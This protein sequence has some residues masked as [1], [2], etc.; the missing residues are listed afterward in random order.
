MSRQP[1]RSFQIWGLAQISTTTCALWSKFRCVKVPLPFYYQRRVADVAALSQPLDDQQRAAIERV[2]CDKCAELDFRA[3]FTYRGEIF[4]FCIVNPFDL[5]QGD[6]LKGKFF[7]QRELAFLE[8]WVGPGA[9]I[10]EVG[11]YVGNH[12]VYYSRFMQP[13]S[14]IVLEPNPEAIA[15]LRRNLEANAVVAA[16]LSLLGIG[17]AAAAASYEL[18]CEGGANRGA[19]RLV[20]AVAGPVR[21]APL[22]DLVDSKV[23]FIKIDVEGMELEVLEGA[24]RVIAASRPKIMI[25]VFRPRIP[26][27]NEMAARASIWH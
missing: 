4:R 17:I 27:F 3:E 20:Q 10:V 14:V 25:E 23:D 1:Y 2:I 21:G 7:E 12:V 15:L 6:F 19:T 9:A 8:D 11:A 16:D 5:I 22:D 26:Q 13:R 18:V 24:A